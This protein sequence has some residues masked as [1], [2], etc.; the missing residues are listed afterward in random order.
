MPPKRAPPKRAPPKRAPP[1]RSTPT[2]TTP[3]RQA[4]ARTTRPAQAGRL[5]PARPREEEDEDDDEEE[6]E[7]E[8][9]EDEEEDEDEEE[10]EEEE[11]P[12]RRKK[13]KRTRSADIHDIFMRTGG[14]NDHHITA[15]KHLPHWEWRSHPIE[16][17]L[18]AQIRAAE[19][20][21]SSSPDRIMDLNNL[22]N[23]TAS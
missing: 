21:G 10:E 23:R 5:I 2:R 6:E 14:V 7:D 8:E 1:K 3:A 15:L 18:K 20:S 9:E 13:K 11:E 22:K 12:P 19:I 16:T 17:T 4:P